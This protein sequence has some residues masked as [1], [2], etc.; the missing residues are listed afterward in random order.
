MIAETQVC[1][2]CKRDI[3]I[4]ELKSGHEECCKGCVAED[5]EGLIFESSLG[6]ETPSLPED[7]PFYFRTRSQKKEY[8]E[9]DSPEPLK[10]LCRETSVHSYQEHIDQRSTNVGREVTKAVLCPKCSESIDPTD[11]SSHDCK[12]TCCDFCQEYYPDDIIATHK[13]YCYHNP[14][15]R[16]ENPHTQ[17]PKEKAAMEP[18]EQP[19]SPGLISRRLEENNQVIDRQQEIVTLPDGVQ[20]LRTIV[21]RPHGYSVEERRIRRPENTAVAGGTV[22]RNPIPAFHEANRNQSGQS[23]QNVQ[24]QTGSN[25][26]GQFGTNQHPFQDHPYFSQPQQTY[27][28]PHQLHQQEARFHQNPNQ[29]SQQ[30]PYHSHYGHQNFMPQYQQPYQQPQNQVEIINPF[31][32]LF[33]NSDHSQANLSGSMGNLLNPFVNFMPQRNLHDSF[34]SFFMFGQN[35]FDPMMQSRAYDAPFTPF[36]NLLRDHVN[37]VR[38]NR[39]R[40]FDP[41]FVVGLLQNYDSNEQNSDHRMPKEELNRIPIIKFAKN[42]NTKPGEEEKCPICL[43]DLEDN[44]EIRNLP[45][46]HIFHPSCIDT[47]LVKN[48][49]CPICKRDVHQGLGMN[50]QPGQ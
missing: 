15:R 10:K 49:A 7:M 26:Q 3:P 21:Q 23:A 12:Y 18:E 2:K 22:I 29:Y 33:G 5:S 44:E 8:E 42:I 32:A 1:S 45:C 25:T 39:N 19:Q 38:I 13:E 41:N 14:Y 37:F 35:P 28:Q 30:N 11:I 47:W 36:D 4:E 50:Q 43:I 20:V 46:K 40:M 17:N 16:Y 24:P 6:S 9:P 34:G 31:T 27:P 48:S